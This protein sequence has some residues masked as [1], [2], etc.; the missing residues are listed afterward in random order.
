MS[1]ILNSLLSD[2]QESKIE[3]EL[4]KLNDEDRISAL[5][6][7]FATDI[8]AYATIASVIYRAYLQC[9][10]ENLEL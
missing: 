5:L 6:C 10:L 4:N 3:D 1:L 7:L 2:E 9:Q 8:V